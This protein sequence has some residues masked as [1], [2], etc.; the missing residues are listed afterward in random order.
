MKKFLIL[1]LGLSLTAA[2][3]DVGGLFDLGSGTRGVFKSEDGGKTFSAANLIAGKGDISGVNV[4]SLV[5]DSSNADI[6]Y[7]GSSNG[8]FKST[9]SAKSWRYILSGIAVASMAV[10]PF[11]SN[12]V[13]AAGLSGGKGKIVKS[14][15]SGTSWVDIYTEASKNNPVTAIAASS[16]N[17]QLILAGLATGE[18]LR[19]MDSGRTWQASKDLASRVMSIK[20]GSSGSVYALAQNG[21]YKSS[22]SG[23]SWVTIS[24]T[25]SGQVLSQIGQNQISVTGFDYLALD[26]RQAAVV[27]LG[28]DQGLFRTVNDGANWAQLA[29][30]VKNASLQVGAVAVNPNNSNNLFAG[31]D[32]TMFQSINGGITWETKVLP[33][34]TLIRII[35][36]NPQSNNMIYLGLSTK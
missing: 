6:L 2:S 34:T 23:S 17:S 1:I 16:S 29:L 5:F 22:D 9:D 14:L 13:Y 10:D 28:T 35:E 32:S 15:D 7:L 21:L 36:V 3:C 12:I 26:K 19:S 4:N 11:S 18:I 24:S 20:F 27:Y 30:P 33:T 25:I 31:I 8:I